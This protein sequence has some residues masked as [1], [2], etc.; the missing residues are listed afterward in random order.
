MRIIRHRHGKRYSSKEI[1]SSPIMSHGHSL[2]EGFRVTCFHFTCGR[3]GEDQ[4]EVEFETDKEAET[5]I[6][7]AQEFIARRVK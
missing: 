5:L 2:S 1:V 6:K 7:S 4:Y 3:S